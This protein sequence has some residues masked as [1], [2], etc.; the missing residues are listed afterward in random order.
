MAVRADSF[1]ISYMLHFV[2]NLIADV[3]ISPSIEVKVSKLGAVN[4]ANDL[5]VLEDFSVNVVRRFLLVVPKFVPSS[6]SMVCVF[7][8]RTPDYLV[9]E[10]AVE[11]I[12][13]LVLVRS[14]VNDCAVL[15][16]DPLASENLQV[17]AVQASARFEV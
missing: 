14:I 1:V 7:K 12:L 17:N 15:K 3:P 5:S 11:S 13:D 16:L 2:I 10:R 8:V 4:A 9:H 6:E